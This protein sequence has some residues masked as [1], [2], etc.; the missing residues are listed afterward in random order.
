MH[1]TNEICAH[2]L[3]RPLAMAYVKPEVAEI[4]TRLEIEVLSERFPACVVAESPWDPENAR[5]RGV[6]PAG[7]PVGRGADRA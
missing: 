5:L 4:G 1:A 2:N 3:G 6:S 7:S